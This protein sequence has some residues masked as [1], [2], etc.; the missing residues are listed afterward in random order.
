M[1]VCIKS[2][3]SYLPQHVL[4]NEMLADEFPEWSVNKISEKL[5]INERRISYDETVLSMAINASKRLFDKS[6][7][8]PKDVDFIILCTQSPDYILPTTACLLQNELGIPVTVGAIDFNQGCSG[9]IYGLSLAKG[10]IYA[11]IAKNVLF[12]TSETYSKYIHPSDKSNRAIFGDG[13]TASWISI[14]SGLKIEEFVLGTD[15]S[16]AQNLIIKNGGSKSPKQNIRDDYEEQEKFESDDFLFMNGNEI[17][18]F[19]INSIPPLISNVLSKNNLHQSEIDY[20]VFHQANS[21]MLKHLR[22]KLEIKEN[23]FIID[24][25]KTGN[26]VSSTIPLILENLIN[27]NHIIENSRLLLA[28]FGVG[29]SWGGVVLRKN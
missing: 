25:G 14:G 12:I 4:T 13:A 26:T 21:F 16:G 17:F 9:Y 5:G 8:L 24:M 27:E 6:G 29:Y 18:N 19:T 15:G 1:N 28:G 2:I 22:S 20:F 23:K 10:L 7:L 3:S 11:N